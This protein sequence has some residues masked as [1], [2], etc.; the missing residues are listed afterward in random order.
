MNSLIP[1]ELLLNI[2]NLYE[3]EGVKDPLCHIKLFTP[4]SNFTWYIIEL[5]KED[6]NLCYGYVKAF[7]DELGYFT[8]E[9]LK[10]VRGGLG[11]PIER[12]ISFKP[13]P[14]SKVKR[15]A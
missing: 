2:P 8:L 10:Q 1:N 14:L 15:C 5:S 6:K 4:D 13:T 9:E 12:D 11:L 3:T 7:E